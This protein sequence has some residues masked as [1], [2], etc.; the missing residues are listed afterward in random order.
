MTIK[1]N[2]RVIL[3][4]MMC[5]LMVCSC[6][7][8]K[9]INETTIASLS[10]CELGDVVKF[11]TYNHKAITW[12]VVRKEEGLYLLECSN[13]IDKKPYSEGG[14][15]INTS[16][17]RFHA[18]EWAKSTLR[19]WLNGDFYAK[20]FDETA[21]KAIV[22]CELI[23]DY[24]VSGLNYKSGGDNT[25]DNV[26]ILS[27]IEIKDILKPLSLIS[28]GNKPFWIRTPAGSNGCDNYICLNDLPRDFN[29]E[30]LSVSEKSGVRP[31]IWITDSEKEVASIPIEIQENKEEKTSTTVKK[32]KCPVCK[33]SGRARYYYGGSALEAILAGEPDYT[34][35]PCSMCDGTGYVKK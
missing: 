30:N 12:N 22:P 28:A 10:E 19:E 6:T 33:G 2:L 35:G 11:G 29:N 20:A 18:N 14:G 34:Y 7:S 24:Y 9:T 3:C 8:Q 4:S 17:E 16:D 27:Y 26:F 15:S 31:A 21:K 13:V 32:V 5:A 1:N 23:N 25:Y